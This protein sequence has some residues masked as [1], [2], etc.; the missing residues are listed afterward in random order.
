MP[1]NFKELEGLECIVSEALVVNL[2]IGDK[3]VGF[4]HISPPRRG[5]S[6]E[7]ET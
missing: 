3:L 5:L 4:H 2:V 1:S 7:A 6:L